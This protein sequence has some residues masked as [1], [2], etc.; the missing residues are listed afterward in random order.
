LAGQPLPE[1][2]GSGG[3]GSD[4]MRRAGSGEIFSH[5]SRSA[6]NTRM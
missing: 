5:K 6:D 1:R 3:V 4:T 2:A